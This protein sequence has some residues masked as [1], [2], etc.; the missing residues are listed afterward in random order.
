MEDRRIY[1]VEDEMVTSELIQGVLHR[2]G[3]QYMGSAESGEKAI[4]ELKKNPVD[5][6]LM[7]IFLGG[8]LTGIETAKYVYEKLRIPVV[9]ITAHSDDKTL[10]DAIKA[11]PFGY[12]VK[13]VDE[14]RLYAIVEV[15]MHKRKLETQLLHINN[16][17]SI[18]KSS[19]KYLLTE[20]DEALMMQ[21]VI[22][23]LVNPRVYKA[24]WAIMLDENS[25]VRA[26]YQ[27]GFGHL[28]TAVER[29]AERGDLGHCMRIAMKQKTGVA[30]DLD[31][32]ECSRCPIRKDYCDNGIIV[33]T[34]SYKEQIYGILYVSLW[35]KTETNKEEINLFEELSNN[36]GF[37]IYRNLLE[38]E[39]VQ[40]NRSLMAITQT[41][42]AL[43]KSNDVNQLVNEVCRIIVT[44]GEYDFAWVGFVNYNNEHWPIQPVAWHGAGKSYMENL[45]LRLASQDN[46][47]G[48]AY[49]AITR[50]EIQI[51]DN[52]T[53]SKRFSPWRENAL[54]YGFR[55]AMVIPLT[56]NQVRVGILNVYSAKLNRFTKHE[57]DLLLQLAANLAF[58]IQNLKIRIEKDKVEAGL[59]ASEQ[60]LNLATEVTDIGIWDWNLVADRITY[61]IRWVEMLGYN[62]EDISSDTS[63]WKS[64][65]HP[66]DRKTV[67]KNLERHLTGKTSEYFQEYRMLTKSGNYIWI[68]DHGKVIHR[69]AEGKPKRAIGIHQDITQW[70]EQE[71]KIRQL[72]T[73][74]EQSPA[75]VIITNTLGEIEYVNPHFTKVTGYDYEEAIGKNPRILKSGRQN[76]SFYST[77]WDTLLNGNTW[78][79]EFCNKTKSG[80]E[81]WESATITPIRND[82][83]QITHYMAIKIDISDKKKAAELLQQT[84]D[85]LKVAQHIAKVG[86][87]IL[88]IGSGLFTYSEEIS[89]IYELS[90][91]ENIENIDSFIDKA[92]EEDRKK[93]KTA[94]KKTLI[95]KAGFEVEYRIRTKSGKVKYLSS[96]AELTYD[97]KGE[98]VQLHGTVQ[99]FSSQKSLELAL[100]KQIEFENV[101]AKLS[102]QFINLPQNQFEAGL[103]IALAQL[104]T[105]TAFDRSYLYLIDENKK[106]FIN[107]IEWVK[108]GVAASHFSNTNLNLSDVKW[109]IKKLRKDLILK[110]NRIGALPKSASKLKTYLE[111][112]SVKS[113]VAIPLFNQEELL[114]FIGLDAVKREKTLSIEMQD[115]IILTVQSITNVIV[116]NKQEKEMQRLNSRMKELSSKLENAREEEKKAIALTLHDELGQMLTAVKLDIFWYMQYFESHKAYNKV[117]EKIKSTLELV[118]NTLDTTRRISHELRPTILDNFGIEAALEWL[119]SNFAT[120]NKI[121]IE[122]GF[123]FEERMMQPDTRV[124]IYRIVQEALTNI[125][126][127][128]EATKVEVFVYARGE[129]LKLEI[130]DNGK[131][132]SQTDIDNSTGLGIF[133]MKERLTRWNGKFEMKGKAG[134]GTEL[135]IS[136]PLENIKTQS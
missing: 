23:N 108:E 40:V 10:H 116:R 78:H 77:L 102:S 100:K 89:Q 127:H 52:I 132:I 47:K 86:N 118:N 85:Q 17:L 109:F 14:A 58:G 84:A 38:L 87:W 129:Y 26:S 2:V 81:F 20:Q 6:V 98:A 97:E 1:I 111:K 18:I 46:F 123:V 57:A 27:C 19:S 113:I 128:A 13:P 32:K 95:K 134:K 73:G 36:I 30:Y 3:Y 54:K 28:S 7:D 60:R 55:S 92:L 115:L 104:G 42:M 62:M 71:I 90:P 114:G 59:I 51:I 33:S 101:I 34:L 45:H 94:M 76:A 126:K 125:I 53:T 66:D 88:D 64:H 106:V 83:E 61:S 69:D 103:K 130:I 43:L 21:K 75:S 80:N 48:P 105:Q 82:K 49:L 120:R 39:K 136:L 124:T 110:I 68:R 133:G 74:V 12:M 107:A 67:L 31:E 122:L 11:N 72:Y 22:D 131:G 35:P 121:E 5:L 112:Q 65:L 15:A 63:F 29:Q 119:I 4:R 56:A 117:S 9:Y 99:D 50:D 79:G 44:I 37:A 70:K 96:L 41:D 135:I 24:A 91:N 8:K 25:E 16:I 93:M